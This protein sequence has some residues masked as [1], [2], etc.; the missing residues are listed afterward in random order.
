MPE[1]IR[2]GILGTGGIAR[3]FAR[4]LQF[5]PDA[6]LLAI[7][8]RSDSGAESFAD[9]FDVPRAYSD[10][11][12]LVNDRDIDVVYVATPSSVHRDNCILGLEAGKAVLC[13]KPFTI[14]ADEAREVISLARQKGLFCMEAMWMR[15]IP[16]MKSLR[17]VM[18]VNGIGDIRMLVAQLGYANEFDPDDRI[19]NPRLGGGALLDLGIYPLSL[20]FH[21]MG[22]PSSIVSQPT[23]GASG[24]DEQLSIIL[25]YP[26]GGQAVLA[27]S[28]RNN[29]SNDAV[30]MGTNGNIKIHAP[31]ITP[32]RLTVMK[33]PDAGSGGGSRGSRL[34][35]LR[36]LPLLQ[37]LYL[38]LDPYLSP[39]L[40][41][42]SSDIVETYKGNG[43]NYEAAEVMRR[44]RSKEIES[45][46]MPLDETL[47]IMET[48]DAVRAQWNLTSPHEARDAE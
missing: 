19:F 5:L 15:F 37:E 33:K 26:D 25:G 10:Y 8:S 1:P 4:G 36:R 9:Q 14:N 23:I 39:L 18:D 16:L 27:A 12:A 22:E 3:R 46:I 20:A 21:L 43:F 31:L 34:S 42:R 32:H 45:P 13:E 11:E 47:K 40:R 29:M 44:L 38:R 17:H 35:F 28:I 7:G 30:I 2:W 41:R 24:V 6:R 48:M